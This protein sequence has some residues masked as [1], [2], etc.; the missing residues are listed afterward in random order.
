MGAGKKVT[1]GVVMVTI[2]KLGLSS[3]SITGKS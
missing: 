2:W 3:P 1:S